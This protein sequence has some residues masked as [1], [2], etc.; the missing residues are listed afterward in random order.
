[1][2]LRHLGEPDAHPARDNP[3]RCRCGR[4]DLPDR[5][6]HRRALGTALASALFFGELARTYGDFHAAAGLGLGSPAV[7]VGVAFLI[8]LVDILRPVRRGATAADVEV[9]R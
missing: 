3:R 4:R 7:L 9:A 5:P 2:R 8:G 6:A 1:M